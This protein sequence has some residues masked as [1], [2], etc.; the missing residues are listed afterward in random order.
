MLFCTSLRGQFAKRSPL[1]CNTIK[2]E[3]FL[4]LK[5]MMKRKWPWRELARVLLLLWARPVQGCLC[6]VGRVTGRAAFQ[7]SA[8]RSGQATDDLKMTGTGLSTGERNHLLG[9]YW[10]SCCEIMSMSHNLLKPWEFFSK[11]FP[12]AL[13]K[14]LTWTADLKTIFKLSVHSRDAYVN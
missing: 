14:T 2:I 1:G 13:S 3:T 12:L 9:K 4:R 10:L 5:S 8:G 7:K 6:D 11:S